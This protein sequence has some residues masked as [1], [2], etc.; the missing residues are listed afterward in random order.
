VADAEKIKNVARRIIRTREAGHQV[1]VVVSAMGD[2][3]R[4]ASLRTGPSAR[5][6]LKKSI[7]TA[8][9]RNWKRDTSLSSPVSRA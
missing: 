5:R 2:T 1:I 7:P 3:T 6:A 9:S 4:P 8:W